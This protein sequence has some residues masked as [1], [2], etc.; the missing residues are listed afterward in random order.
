[1]SS[2]LLFFD[3]HQGL[4]AAVGVFVPIWIFSRQ[5][6]KSYF[7][8]ERDNFNEIFKD[9][10][11][12]QLPE[13]LYDMEAVSTEE[14]NDR[15][16]ELSLLLEKMRKS[17][18]YYKYAMP[19][20]YRCLEI[21]ILDIK[22]LA[23]HGDGWSMY[24]SKSQQNRLIQK[25]CRRLIKDI[26]NASKGK[27]ISIRMF[28]WGFFQGIRSFF[29]KN[30][31]SYPSDRI[32][33][34]FVPGSVNIFGFS[35]D[36][37]TKNIETNNFRRLPGKDLTIY[38]LDDNISIKNVYCSTP[39][40]HIYFWYKNNF[41][42]GTDIGTPEA[43]V[44]NDINS[45]IRYNKDIASVSWNDNSY[46]TIVVLWEEAESPSKIRFGHFNVRSI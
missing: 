22:N 32:M 18:K 35:S 41:R 3:N 36:N 9:F 30:L 33:N 23:R 19:F 39:S 26:Q 31:V 6:S 45:T 10:T 15:F 4:I 17:S 1:M 12:H 40:S 34:T 16:S 25:K 8:M 46:H 14:W 24:R 29:I 28:Q 20:F 21:R 27:V 37:A 42:W 44:I 5:L 38:C 11:M 2:L 7:T 13:I 43:Q